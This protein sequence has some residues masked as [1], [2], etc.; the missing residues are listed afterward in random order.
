V[1]DYF[2]WGPELKTG[3][4]LI[5]EQHKRLFDL[6]SQMWNCRE[7]TLEKKKQLFEQILKVLQAHCIDEERILSEIEYAFLEE[8]QNEH[9]EL[10]NQF[11]LLLDSCSNDNR[12]TWYKMMS[13]LA[14]ELLLNH[15]L[16]TDLEYEKFM[17][18]SF[19]ES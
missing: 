15:L 13:F 6:T 12:Q 8:H 18:K 19:P 17:R 4:A 1:K 2:A 11:K 10:I 14:Q 5:D 7:E 9:R 3:N 16:G